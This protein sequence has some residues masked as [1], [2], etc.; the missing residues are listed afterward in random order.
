M[1]STLVGSIA[2]L[3]FGLSV[4]AQ[5]FAWTDAAT[6]ID[7]QRYYDSDSGFSFGVA[8]PENI[9]TDFIG[10]I[11]VPLTSSAG[12]GGVSFGGPMTGN[13]LFVAWTDGDEIKTSFRMAT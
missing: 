9:S 13:V 5:S 10:Q 6:G 2:A 12:W 1:R 7:F 3:S 4:S 11:V 8:A